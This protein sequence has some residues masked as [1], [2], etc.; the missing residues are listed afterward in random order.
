MQ[1][2]LTPAFVMKAPL[3]ERGD[4]VVYWD[5]ALPCFG[6]MVTTNG[7]K[8]FV[9][10]YRSNG[11]SRRLT[12]KAA[13][14]GGLSLNEAKR[15]AKAIIGSVT[16]G[17]DPL[18]D[19]RSASRAAENTLQAIAE[20][21]FARDGAKLRSLRMQRL[22]LE[23]LVYPRLGARQIDDIRRTDLVRL[24]DKIA[25]ESGPRMADITLAFLRRILN[26]H[27][28]RSDDFRSPI[29]RG[30]ARTKPSQRR[31]QRILNDDEIRAVWRA[32]EAQPNAFNCLVRFLLLTATRRTEAARMERSEVSGTEWTIPQAR[33]KTGLEL[34]VPLSPTAQAILAKT[35]KL[36]TRFVFTNDGKHAL[37]SFSKFK[38]K[39]DKASGVTGWTLHDL[40]RTAR[41]LMSRAGVPSDHAERCLGHVMGGIRGTYDRHEY[42]NEKR[43]AFEALASL[44][45]GIVHP[46]ANVTP[47]R[48]KRS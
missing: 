18:A 4:R 16:K 45:E 6:L 31:R 1:K 11:V 46:K 35:P 38:P 5:E 32:T 13:P 23:R 43:H 30:M 47:L 40:R 8:S 28:S 10:Q 39:L 15:E 14:Q 21:F 26:W 17:G 41:S 33:Y 24:L 19:R 48:D 20:E 29:V 7:H 37:A 34:L 27:A 25:D 42:I 36:G 22:T 3:P 12:L 9:V 2:K 44:I